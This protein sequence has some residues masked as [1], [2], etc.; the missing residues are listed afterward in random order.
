MITATQ[1]LD[2]PLFPLR[3]VSHSTPKISNFLF[4][5]RKTL[6]VLKPGV[7]SNQKVEFESSWAMIH[8]GIL[9]FNQ[10]LLVTYPTMQWKIL[11]RKKGFTRN[12]MYC[13]PFLCTYHI[14]FY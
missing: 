10:E 14:F 9:G 1:I 11:T 5:L 3:N 4:K 12:Q 2:S 13:A 7:R 6:N 8:A